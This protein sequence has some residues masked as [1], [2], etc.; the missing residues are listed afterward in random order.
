VRQL[1]KA[2]PAFS[3]ELRLAYRY[4]QPDAASSLTKSRIILEKLLV[5]VYVKE[6]GK[7]PRKPLLAEMLADNQFTSKIERRILSRMNG[8]RDLG[9]LG[10]HG[11]NV[12]PSDAARVLDDLCE[13]LDWYLPRDGKQP[14]TGRVI[15]ASGRLIE[16]AEQSEDSP[17]PG[18]S[19][20]IPGYAEDTTQGATSG[21]EKS[22]ELRQP[23]SPS[24]HAPVESRYRLRVIAGPVSGN[25]IP[26]ARDRL[27]LGR[28]PDCDIRLDD[29]YCSRCHCALE[30]DLVQQS[31]ILVLFGS[32]PLVVV[33]GVLAKDS[34]KVGEADELR[35]G[36]NLLVIERG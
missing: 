32:R 21:T 5:Q 16:V 22:P 8:I 29:P 27:T 36:A 35:I 10:P 34:V 23:D 19:E 1:D 12:E 26:L 6:M 7:E 9:N 15:L 13:V 33:N 11:E 4:I 14:S 20:D 25:V 30:W 17:A 2:L 3:E 24:R 28:S 18:V 31:F